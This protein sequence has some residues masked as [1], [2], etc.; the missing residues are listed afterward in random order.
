MS[1]ELSEKLSNFATQACEKNGDACIT[2]TSH[3][4]PEMT[5][6]KL[7]DGRSLGLIQKI[8]WEIGL[9]DFS[10]AKITT[11]LTPAELKVMLKDAEFHVQPAERYGPFRYLWDW[12]ISRLYL[13]VTN[14]RKNKK[15]G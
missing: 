7:S 2:I 14:P 9:G 11:I 8:E 4:T 3:G 15:G 6:A 12:T 10:R 1:S 13:W 5:K